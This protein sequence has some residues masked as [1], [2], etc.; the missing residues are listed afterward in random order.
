M[1]DETTLAHLAHHHVQHVAQAIEL[2]GVEWIV[3][4]FPVTNP[5]KPRQHK[6][7]LYGR[8]WRLR[9][10][11]IDAM[12]RQLPSDEYVLIARRFEGE[13]KNV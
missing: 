10:Q 7:A 1:G 4:H 8:M 6:S 2:V 5:D 3:F 13:V 12:V 9:E 11:G